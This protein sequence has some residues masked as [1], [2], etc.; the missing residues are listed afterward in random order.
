MIRFTTIGCVGAHLDI[1]VSDRE[2][3]TALVNVHQGIAHADVGHV[4]VQSDVRR[5]PLEPQPD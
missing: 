1:D 2:V 4:R 3:P 5:R